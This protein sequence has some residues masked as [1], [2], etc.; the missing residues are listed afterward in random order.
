MASKGSI[1]YL[2]PRLKHQLKTVSNECKV[3]RKLLSLEGEKTKTQI[4]LLDINEGDINQLTF[5]SMG[6]ALKKIN[7]YHPNVQDGDIDSRSLI[8]TADYLFNNKHNENVAPVYTKGRNS[9]KIGRLANKLFNNEFTNQ[10]IEKFTNLVKSSRKRLN[11]KMRIVKGDDIAEWYDFNNYFNQNS[12]LG[13]SCMKSMSK[14][15]FDIYTK[16]E[17]VSLL[18]LESCGKLIGRALVW[19]INTV[20][21]DEIKAEFY[22]D[23]VYTNNDHHHFKFIKFAKDNNWCYRKY[24]GSSF[25][26]E[27]CY[28]ENNYYG[29]DISIKLK[30]GLKYNRY[31][32]MDTFGRYDEKKGLL[33]SDSDS[34]K[35]GHI[36][37]GTD[38]CYQKS[39][40]K[41]KA[42]VNKLSSFFKR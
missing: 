4:T 3:T 38:G 24:Q 19:K 25:H 20:S 33:F 13:S 17:N 14:D 16:N 9:I 36:L 31:P 23:R 18:I 26:R 39:I 8:G 34:D 29:V 1:L 2:S 42:I 30:K 28:G 27:V 12:N 15:T 7:E 6:N 41:T 37:K 10:E 11:E 35:Y 32:Y 21:D 40:S 5:I 22:M